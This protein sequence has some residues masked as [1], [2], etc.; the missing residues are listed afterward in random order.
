MLKIP[1][2]IP[3]G[4][5]VCSNF[6]K[7][8]YALASIIGGSLLCMIYPIAGRYSALFIA[9]GVIV[10]IRVLVSMFRWSIPRGEQLQRMHGRSIK[11]T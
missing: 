8:I 5:F 2:G 6:T 11:K 10:I 3:D 1:S 4:I 7:H 9:A